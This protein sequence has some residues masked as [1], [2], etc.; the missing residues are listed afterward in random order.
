MVLIEYWGLVPIKKA[1]RRMLLTI[2][3]FELFGKQLN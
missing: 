1:S 2:E 3:L